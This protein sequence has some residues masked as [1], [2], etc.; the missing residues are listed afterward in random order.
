MT[1]SNEKTIFHV[2]HRDLVGKKVGQLRQEGSLPANIYGL[3]LDSET[4]AVDYAGFTKLYESEGDTGLVYLVVEGSKKEIPVLIDQVDYHPV[5]N[6]ATHVVFRRVNLLEK[7]TAEV[8]VELVGENE[9]PDATVL[10]V[11]DALEVS[12]LPADLPDNFEVDISGLKEFGDSITI[13]DLSYDKS[14]IEIVLEGELDLESPLVILQE[15]KEE[16][17]PEE[18]VSVDDVEVTTEKAEKD[19]GPSSTEDTNASQEE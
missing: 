5:S 10:M 2:K 16:E 4:V 13:G 18:E 15:V 8:P 14:K 3:G 11:R 1:T 7:I 19:E 17:E 12:A 6:A 9:V